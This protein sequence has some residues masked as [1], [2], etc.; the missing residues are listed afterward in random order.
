M[1]RL[2]TALTTFRLRGRAHLV[3][4]H[5]S[6]RARRVAVILGV[7]LII[8]GLLGFFAAPPLMHRWMDTHASALLGR[9]VSVGVLHFNPFTLKLDA[10]QLHVGDADGHAPF[11]D[12][13]HLTLNGSWSSLFRL[14]PV[15]D[16]LTVLNPRIVISRSA[17]Q[18]F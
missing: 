10:D 6:R 11:V 17:P 14:A 18:R 15:L 12:I 16:E 5:R 4:L 8:Y 2:T 9:P 1:S 3:A 7:L 13:E